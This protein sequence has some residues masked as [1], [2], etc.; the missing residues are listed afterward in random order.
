M[1][2]REAYQIPPAMRPPDPPP[3]RPGL[4]VSPAERTFLRPVPT[5]VPRPPTRYEPGAFEGAWGVALAVV[6]PLIVAFAA[7]ALLTLL[8]WGAP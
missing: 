5:S 7:G 4:Y 8:L 3:M 6:W 2:A 1:R